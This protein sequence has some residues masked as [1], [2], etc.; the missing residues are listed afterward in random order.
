MVNG[1][2]RVQ[3]LG[4]Y[5]RQQSVVTTRPLKTTLTNSNSHDEYNEIIEAG[6]K[7]P[8]TTETY[9]RPSNDENNVFYLF[10]RILFI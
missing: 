7:E 9:S 10:W 1:V 6:S 5:D 8:I 4:K 3:K 2:D